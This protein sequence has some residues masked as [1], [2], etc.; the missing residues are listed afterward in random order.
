MFVAVASLALVEYARAGTIFDRTITER[1]TRG[2]AFREGVDLDTNFFLSSGAETI[3]GGAEG[4]L[5]AS[6]LISAGRRLCELVDVVERKFTVTDRP[7]NALHT[8][9]L[10]GNWDGLQTADVEGAFYVLHIYY[11]D[12]VFEIVDSG[13]I[14]RAVLNDTDSQ[15]ERRRNQGPVQ[16]N[17]S[18]DKSQPLRLLPGD[19]LLRSTVTFTAYYEQAGWMLNLRD[20]IF[21]PQGI[22]SGGDTRG[23]Q[24]R[25]TPPEVLPPPTPIP[26]PSSLGLIGIGACAITD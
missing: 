23:F 19:Y 5:G 10:S 12:E 24:S 13:M 6:T 17:I 3:E 4:E 11:T 15:N 7:E 25:L 14:R 26:G 2:G 20:E 21:G 8:L 9:L 18:L 1:L 16:K 22:G